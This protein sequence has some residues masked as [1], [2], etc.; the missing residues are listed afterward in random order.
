MREMA[1]V[2]MVAGD[3]EGEGGMVMARGTRMVGK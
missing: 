2:I 1:M 3:K